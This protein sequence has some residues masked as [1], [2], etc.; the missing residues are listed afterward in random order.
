[1][2]PVYAGSELRMGDPITAHW[3]RAAVLAAICAVSGCSASRTNVDAGAIVDI[4][5]DEGFDGAR[6]AAPPPWP[7]PLPVEP[8][9]PVL[10]VPGLDVASAVEL[11]ADGRGLFLGADVATPTV[12]RE[13][14]LFGY[15]G[16]A[17]MAWTREPYSVGGAPITI[18][19]QPGGALHVWP[20]LGG[21]WRHEGPTSVT[22]VE[23]LYGVIADVPTRGG[24]VTQE[25]GHVRYAFEVLQ[26]DYPFCDHYVGMW[27]D[28]FRLFGLCRN[29][30]DVVAPTGTGERTDLPG[31]PYAAVWGQGPSEV[32]VA[33]RDG[34]LFLLAP[35]GL[36]TIDTPSADVVDVWRAED[37]L[38]ILGE[39]SL[40]R[41]S[42]E[43]GATLVASWA[44][45][46]NIGAAV[47]R[48]DTTTYMALVDRTGAARPCGAARVI[49][50][51]DSGIAHWL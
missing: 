32:G 35:A 51:E 2:A 21:V 40:S 11:Y 42:P 34:R 36:E 29:K 14:A 44:G 1:M 46:E 4:G 6:D 31:G 49:A 27:A 28:E 39:S 41:W 19:A 23:G 5:V 8:S 22:F 48:R 43:D 38:Y 45:A 17:W 3:M 15:E 25:R 33:A 20:A 12:I 10:C 47:A 26:A 13:V 9:A 18:S 24:Y 7:S 30:L 37:G 16:E 50:L